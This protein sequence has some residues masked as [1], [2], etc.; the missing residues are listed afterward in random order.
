MDV[1]RRVPRIEA[2]QLKE[3]NKTELLTWGGLAESTLDNLKM[4]EGEYL[5]KE[6]TSPRS[7]SVRVMTPEEFD[8]YYSKKPLEES[9]WDAVYSVCD[10]YHDDRDRSDAFLCLDE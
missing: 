6:Q 3:D 5:V 4:E 1:Y 2:V 8:F 7:F 10:Q 9:V